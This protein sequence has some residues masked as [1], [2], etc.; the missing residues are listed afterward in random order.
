MPAVHTKDAKRDAARAE[1]FY[2]HENL[3]YNEAFLI[4]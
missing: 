3:N 2:N 1:I 4:N